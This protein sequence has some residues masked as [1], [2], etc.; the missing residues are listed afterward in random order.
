MKLQSVDDLVDHLALGAHRE[1]DEIE[2]D[3]DH[4][5]DRLAVGG[6]SSQ[7]ADGADPPTLLSPPTSCSP[8]NPGQ[9]G[10]WLMSASGAQNTLD[11]QDYGRR[12][13]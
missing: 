12:A 6:V 7:R 4:C 10:Y 8:P 11:S 2:F 5:A 9:V 1:P 3:A 13:T